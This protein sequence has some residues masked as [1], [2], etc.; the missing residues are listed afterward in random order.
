M[1]NID[2]SILFYTANGSQ[3]NE[4]TFSVYNAVNNNNVSKIDLARQTQS[5]RGSKDWDGGTYD[6]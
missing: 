4:W 5:N 6:K 2:R 3:N 1:S